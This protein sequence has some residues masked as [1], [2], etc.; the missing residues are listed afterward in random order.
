MR[1]RRGVRSLDEQAHTTLRAD[2]SKLEI[3]FDAM[4]ICL[5]HYDVTQPSRLST[6]PPVPLTTCITAVDNIQWALRVSPGLA[7]TLPGC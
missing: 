3:C 4:N 2:D 7:T 5:R 6:S 1:A